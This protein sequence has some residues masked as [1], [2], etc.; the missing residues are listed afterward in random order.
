RKP[1]IPVEVRNALEVLGLKGD[2]IDFPTLKKQ[3]RTRMH[4]YHP[5]KVSGL[6]EDL[7]RLA[8]ERTKA[9]V[10]A[11]KIAERYFKEVTQE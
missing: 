3:F 11:Y 8:E 9:F 5:D 1:K 2:D 4:E 7:R 6:G 10:A